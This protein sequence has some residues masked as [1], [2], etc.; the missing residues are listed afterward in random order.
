MKQNTITTHAP[1][2]DEKADTALQNGS[3]P[4]FQQ[5]HKGSPL[6]ALV[7]LAGDIVTIVFV[8]LWMFRWR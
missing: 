1:E 7:V 4:Y 3:P 5:P 2:R 8:L 6:V